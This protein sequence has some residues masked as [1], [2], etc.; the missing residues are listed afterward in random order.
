MA[1]KINRNGCTR[2]VFIFKKI[3]VKIPN[4]TY[5]WE[6]FLKGLIANIHESKCWKYNSGKFETGLSSLLCPVLWCSYGGWILIMKKAK[7][8]TD[9]EFIESDISEHIKHFAGDDK[10]DSYGWINDNI[11]KIDYGQ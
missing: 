9:L 2:I 6:H 4:F 5:S 7:V 10:S 11:V 3:V 8:L 1:I